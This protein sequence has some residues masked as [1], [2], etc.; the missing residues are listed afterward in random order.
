MK[1]SVIVLATLA[2]N[3][4]V[5]AQPPKAQNQ[6][7]KRGD[8]KSN[9]ALLNLWGE[10]PEAV[11]ELYATAYN[12]LASRRDASFGDLATDATFQSL[13]RQGGV[14]H[15]GGPMLGA[16]TPDSVRVW[17]RTCRPA[18]VEVRVDVDGM[19][20]TFGPVSSTLESELVAVV[21]VT[22][23]ASKRSATPAYIY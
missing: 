7:I 6:Q 13:C 15:L 5:D 10:K 1:A 18:K 8:L 22:G 21:P 4:T 23:L 19:E 12:V 16:I 2:L 17:L 3:S 9:M 20:R 11:Q 14:T